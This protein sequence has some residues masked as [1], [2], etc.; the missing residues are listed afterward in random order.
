MLDKRAGQVSFLFV[1]RV[2]RKKNLAAAIDLVAS[3]HGDVI[4][5]I[6]GPVDDSG[7]WQECQQA[8]A[9]VP[10]NVQIRYMGAVPHDEAC[11]KFAQYHFF[12]FPT[13]S[14]NF[15]HVIVE[16]LSGGCPV[17]VSDQTPWSNLEA[18]GIGWDLPLDDDS[19]WRQVLQ[20]CADMDGEI[21]RQMSRTCLD[22]IREWA[23][24]PAIR[25]ENA[26]L[27]RRAVGQSETEGEKDHLPEKHAAD[28][29]SSH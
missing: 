23:C 26:R 6:Y 1:S 2:S 24:S 9:G 16:A 22:F 14:E 15:G 11:E 5:D 13:L 19:R 27:F 20:A 28:E 29:M 17:I 21:Y 25:D 12:L 10:R 3:V 7:Y 4:F 18:K 8:M